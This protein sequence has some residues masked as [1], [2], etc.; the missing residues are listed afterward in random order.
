MIA[1]VFARFDANRCAEEL[2]SKT[3]GINS[4]EQLVE[5]REWLCFAE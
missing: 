2:P 1:V 4:D 5:F 3:N